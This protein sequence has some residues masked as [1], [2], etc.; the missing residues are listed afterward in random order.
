MFNLEEKIGFIQGRLSSL[1]N[2]KIQAFPYNYWQQEFVDA[3]SIN[4]KRMEWTI[5]IDDIYKNPIMSNDG[6]KKIKYLSQ[7][8]LINIPSLTGDCFMQMPFWKNNQSY[9][10]SLK[11]IFLDV[12]YASSEIGIKYVVVPLVDNGSVKTI[13]EENI[14]RDFL[15]ENLF[16]LKDN[17][18]Q[19]LFESDYEPLLLKDFIGKFPDQYFGINY[20]IGNSASLGFDPDLEF[21]LIGKY[22]KNV[23]I[24]D[25][26][27][28]GPTVYLGEGDAK[29]EKV[30]RNLKEY[31]YK[32]NF[33]I[34]GAR[35]KK[36]EHKK[37]LLEYKN[38]TL[39]LMK[40]YYI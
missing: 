25:R 16:L 20:D 24:K 22:I 9:S 21:K 6:R 18:I 11:K 31:S 17:D 35:S 36:N 23:H 19:I 26:K 4:F 33:I 32:G 10:E 14:L 13:E 30:F 5:D 38:F 37:K 27:F 8:Y 15:L 12:L 29:F 40:H 2:G 39:S 28:M 34:Q 1:V 3:N 7:K